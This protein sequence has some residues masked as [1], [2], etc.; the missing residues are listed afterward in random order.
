M[1]L[2]LGPQFDGVLMAARAGADWAWELLYDELSPVV[3]GYVRGRG[4]AEPEDLVGETFLHVVRNV[5]TFDGD[6]RAFRGWV[7]GIAHRRLVDELRKRARRPVASA[8]VDDY[9]VADPD[10]DP[11]EVAVARA[12][13]AGVLSVVRRLTP[14]QQA[15]LLLRLVGELSLA[16]VAEVLGKRLP[17]VKALQRRALVA[18]DREMSRLGVSR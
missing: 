11:A 8:P 7:L 10:A 15:V 1:T 12:E 18:L 9:E 13:V 17:A 2:G 16:E 5:S 4:A 14:D 6:E 3:F